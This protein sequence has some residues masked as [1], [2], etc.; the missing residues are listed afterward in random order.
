MGREG[1]AKRTDILRG[2]EE[3][4]LG[5]TTCIISNEH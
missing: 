1:A 2:A 4:G 3:Q 5:L